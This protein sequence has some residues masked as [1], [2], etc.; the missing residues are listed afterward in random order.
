MNDLLFSVLG[1]IAPILV[2][3]LVLIFGRR[4]VVDTLGSVLG[5]CRRGGFGPG[6]RWRTAGP[7]GPLR[8]HVKLRVMW[9]DQ[10]YKAVISLA[11]VNRRNS[12]LLP[13]RN[14]TT[15]LVTPWQVPESGPLRRP[16]IV[17]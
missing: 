9:A 5:L 8:E 13:E 6:P 7:S 2:F 16:R 12:T 17:V 3:F 4:L 14:Q 10:A 15:V 1:A 11:S